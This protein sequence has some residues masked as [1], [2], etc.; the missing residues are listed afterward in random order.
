MMIA[1]SSLCAL[2]AS[3]S[4]NASFVTKVSEPGAV[5]ME[6]SRK[7]RH[8]RVAMLRTLTQPLPKGEEKTARRSDTTPR[9]HAESLSSTACAGAVSFSSTAAS[10]G[11]GFRLHGSR[12]PENGY[13]VEFPH[14]NRVCC[15]SDRNDLSRNYGD[16][17]CNYSHCS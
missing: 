4:A 6:S 9:A 14:C 3:S 11:L 5:A 15:H 17:S 1:I 8:D 12:L 10:L 13:F 2:Y 7:F 16:L